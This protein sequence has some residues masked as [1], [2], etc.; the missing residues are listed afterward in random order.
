M[1][2]NELDTIDKKIELIRENILKVVGNPSL[3]IDAKREL[4]EIKEEQAKQLLDQKIE[5]GWTN[6]RADNLILIEFQKLKEGITKGEFDQQYNLSGQ[7]ESDKLGRFSSEI[8]ENDKQYKHLR[9]IAELFDKRDKIENYLLAQCIKPTIRNG[10][11]YTKLSKSL[12]QQHKASYD[13]QIKNRF[14]T[15]NRFL[16]PLGYKVK[17]RSK[18]SII[19]IIL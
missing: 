10:S 17:F 9:K 1:D 6:R 2:K 19:E 13:K 3:T 14:R 11:K 7:P 15:F 18:T 12:Y 16:K 5:L 4:I 8:P